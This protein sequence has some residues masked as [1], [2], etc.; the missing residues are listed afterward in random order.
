VNE[1]GGRVVNQRAQP[2]SIGEYSPS[3]RKLRLQRNF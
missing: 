3:E 1:G 2:Q